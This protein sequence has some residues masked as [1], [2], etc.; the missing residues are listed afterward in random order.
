MRKPIRI[1][2][3][4]RAKIAGQRFY[5]VGSDYIRRK[6][7][8]DDETFRAPEDEVEWIGRDRKRFEAIFN[9]RRCNG[10]WRGERHPM[11]KC[12][13][14]MKAEILERQ[15]ESY[16]GFDRNYAD[17]LHEQAAACRALAPK[18]QHHD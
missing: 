13:H 16:E 8:F 11:G 14:L 3:P 7:P 18:A 17:V 10:L 9:W 12:L 5:E 6:R 15:A 1:Y 2:P 4:K